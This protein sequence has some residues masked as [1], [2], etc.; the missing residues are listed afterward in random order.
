MEVV[1]E[2]LREAVVVKVVGVVEVHHRLE[3]WPFLRL[4]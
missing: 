3:L 1:V 4:Q 2:Q